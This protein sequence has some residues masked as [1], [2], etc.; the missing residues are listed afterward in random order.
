ML[1]SIFNLRAYD[2]KSFKYQIIIIVLV[3]GCIGMFLINI[4]QDSD[5]NM[6]EKQ[7]LGYMIG[8][9]AMLIVSFVDYHFICK[10]WV[11][12]YIFNLALLLFCKFTD[13]SMGLPL[14]GYKHYTAK[15]WIRVGSSGFEFMPSELTKIILIIFL[16][17][18]FAITQ[19]YVKKFLNLVIVTILMA[20][21]TYLVFDQP[22]LSTTII[23]LSFFAFV[24]LAAGV[25][26]KIIIPII[27]IGVPAVCAFVWYIM[28]DYVHILEDY[29]KQRVLSLIYPELH[30]DEMYQQNNAAAAI[31]SGGL[32]GKLFTGDT[33][34]R[35]WAY[36]PVKESDFIFSAIGEEFGML[37]CFIV[38]G[39]YTA[40]VIMGIRIAKKAMD[41]KGT[42][43]AIGITALFGMQAFV[44][45]GVV[46]SLLPNTGIPLPFVSSGLSALLSNLATVGLLLNVSMQP[47][48][49]KTPLPEEE[50]VKKS[51]IFY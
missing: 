44:N 27:L 7:L 25:S 39:L 18:Y 11:P 3:L 42:L 15:R 14:Y 41:K 51:R 43:I 49:R 16:A 34:Q 17:E 2:Y 4:M 10:L 37:G 32:L 28:Q 30:P 12:L 22:D 19:R 29:Q 33:S 8:L 36:V 38:I 9:V 23:L 13:K 31:R 5:E 46:T 45:I 40:M 6:F 20:V 48:A 1:H 24:V 50:I 26:F 21:P 35:G 47:K